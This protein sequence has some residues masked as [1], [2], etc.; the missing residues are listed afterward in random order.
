MVSLKRGG[1]GNEVRRIQEWLCLNGF[2]IASDGVYGAVTEVSIRAFRRDR[3][4]RDQ[5]LIDAADFVRLSALMQNA[6]TTGRSLPTDLGASVVRVAH[7]HLAQ[8]PREIGGQNRGPWV[9][10]NMV[11]NEGADYPWSSDSYGSSSARALR[12]LMSRCPWWRLVPATFL[13]PTAA[14]GISWFGTLTSTVRTPLGHCRVARC[15]CGTGNRATGHARAGEDLEA[16]ACH[17]IY[18]L[19]L[20]DG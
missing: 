15:C 10:L 8:H 3:S 6:L 16:R 7:L 11:G 17:V 5:D 1:R 4:T 9:R 14:N 19:P 18:W 2:G 20:P 13:P 12:R